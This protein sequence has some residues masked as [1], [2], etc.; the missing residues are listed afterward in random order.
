MAKK[1][2]PGTSSILIV[3]LRYIGDVLV[4][5][6]LALSL[7][8][9]FP[10]AKIDYLVFAGTEKA[11]RKNPLVRKVITLPRKRKSIGL[12]CSL[13]RSYD[14]AVAAYP[15]DRTAIAAAIAGKRSVGLIYDWKREWWKKLI[16]HDY[17]FCDDRMH[18]V[19]AVLTLTR[20]LGIAPIPRV[21]MAYDDDDVAFA[22]KNIH[23]ERYILLHPYS[24]K[25]CKYWPAECWGRLAALI[26]EHTD[27]TAVFTATPAHSD[28][29]YLEEILSFAPHDVL[30]FPCDLNQFAAALK[31]CAAYVGIDTAPTHIAAAVEAPTIALYGPIPT[32]Y[33]APWP[34]GCEEQS[35][36]AANKG[37]Q[38]KG[39]ITVVQKEWDCV[40]CD[41]ETCRI[42]TRDRMECLE[43]ITP[44]EVLQEIISRLKTR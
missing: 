21:S 26:H 25:R 33:W 30:T 35:P 5:T 41:K 28:N 18:V 20:A 39:H 24:L 37:I 34:N 4:T 10:D 38:R 7:K 19:P 27:C 29:V 15:S 8:T 3:A 16:L 22:R 11:V 1:T 23:A 2:T 9:A 44:E 14:L 42:S 12:L 6:P 32:R 43:A 40:P 13:F 36:F 31:D 17:C